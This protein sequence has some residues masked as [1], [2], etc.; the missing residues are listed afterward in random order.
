MQYH[1][2]GLRLDLYSRTRATV[3]PLEPERLH[4]REVKYLQ[5]DLVMTFWVLGS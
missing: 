2:F 1:Y 5:L 3:W 4:G